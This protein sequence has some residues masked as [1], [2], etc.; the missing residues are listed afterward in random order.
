M[1]RTRMLR[2]LR[3]QSLIEYIILLI[4]VVSAVAA[5]KMYLLR[6]VKAQFKIMQEQITDPEKQEPDVSTTFHG[7]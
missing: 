1:Q 5:M 6:S 3:S 7:S 4:I 2:K